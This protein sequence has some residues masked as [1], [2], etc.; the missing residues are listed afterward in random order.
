MESLKTLIEK[1]FG[2]IVYFAN[3][4]CTWQKDLV[5]YTNKLLRQYIPK[6]SDFKEFSPKHLAKIQHKLN[7]TPREKLNFFTL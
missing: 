6:G 1:E 4:Y 5:E 3:S 2:V 7:K